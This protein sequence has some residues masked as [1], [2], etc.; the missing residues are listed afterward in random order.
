MKEK[1]LYLCKLDLIIAYEQQYKHS[2]RKGLSFL[3]KISS[4]EFPTKVGYGNRLP[5]LHSNKAFVFY[6][7]SLPLLIP[8]GFLIGCPGSLGGFLG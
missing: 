1:P 5:P 6:L 8:L 7:L 3:I 2:E 4:M